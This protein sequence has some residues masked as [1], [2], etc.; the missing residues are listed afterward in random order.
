M[1]D[2]RRAHWDEI[3]LANVNV[4]RTASV[5]SQVLGKLIVD[6]YRAT[7]EL[8]ALEARS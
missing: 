6:E 5:S 2:G 3:G 1:V 8:P 7:I 4:R